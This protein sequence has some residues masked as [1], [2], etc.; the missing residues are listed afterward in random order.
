MFFANPSSTSSSIAPQVSDKG[1]FSV[2]PHELEC[3]KKKRIAPTEV[4]FAI[5]TEPLG[6]VTVAR[7]NVLEGDREVD[8]EEVEIANTPKTKLFLGKLFRLSLFGQEV[9]HSG[10]KK[11]SHVVMCME[12]VPELLSRCQSRCV[13]QPRLMAGLALEVIT[14]EV[15]LA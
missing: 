12:G 1:V 5:I 9:H 6:G 13:N 15:R 7:I 14:K 2:L 4:Y 10:S 11:L 3:K 8:Q